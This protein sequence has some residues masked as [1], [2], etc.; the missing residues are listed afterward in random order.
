MQ[1]NN[2]RDQ[3]NMGP[4]MGM[5][6]PPG[7]NPQILQQLGI[8][9]PITNTVFVANVSASQNASKL[10]ALPKLSLLSDLPLIPI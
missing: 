4:G 3:G 9:P 6:V 5:G 2:M 7:V 1:H 8:E 10:N